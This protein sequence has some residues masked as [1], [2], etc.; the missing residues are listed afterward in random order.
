MKILLNILKFLL[1]L[2]VSYILFFYITSD[3]ISFFFQGSFRFEQVL[4][5]ICFAAQTFFIYYL[6]THS[7]SKEVSPLQ[8]KLVWLLYACIMLILL[9]GRAYIETSINLNVLELFSL[10]S[11]SF[12]QNL[13]N[14][15]LFI[16]IGFLFKAKN[17]IT[18]VLL[19]AILFVILIECLQLI[20]HRGIFDIND[21]ILNTCGIVFGYYLSPRI[22]NN[23]KLQ[24]L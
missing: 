8:V 12:F 10:N 21:I 9:F 7:T 17:K 19:K 16:P 23:L 18:D 4:Y 13:F 24:I 20:T 6:F 3:F 2:F 11:Y 1:C 22:P 14:F 15:L 5:I